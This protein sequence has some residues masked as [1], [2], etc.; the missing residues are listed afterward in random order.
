M[1]ALGTPLKNGSEFD[2]KIDGVKDFGVFV[3]F[4]HHSGLVHISQLRSEGGDATEHFKVGESL[5]VKVMGVDQKGRL[6]L[7]H[8]ATQA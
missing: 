6:K 2:A 4:D 8:L 1:K 3:S 5:K 7:S